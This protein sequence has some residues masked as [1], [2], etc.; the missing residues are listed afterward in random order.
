M[1]TNTVVWFEI[2]VT[3]IAR[4]TAFYSKVM[5]CKMET[6]E[7]GPTKMAIFPGSGQESVHGALVQGPGYTPSATGPLLYM[8][9]GTDLSSALAK[10]APA[11]G[12]VVQEKMS[13]GQHGFCAIFMDTE[14]NR[15][16]LHS[17]Q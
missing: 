2:P 7:M 12:K 1:S 15:V 9:G 8:N 17:M 4:A 13:I 6:A 14:G 16:A 10:V 11:G 5:N 3:D